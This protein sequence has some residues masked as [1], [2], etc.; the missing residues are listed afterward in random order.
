MVTAALGE[1]EVV[2]VTAALGEGEV[3]TT[4]TALGEGERWGRYK[5]IVHQR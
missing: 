2:M 5:Y 4:A 3:V 1:G